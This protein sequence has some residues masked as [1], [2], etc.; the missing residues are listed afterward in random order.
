MARSEARDSRVQTGVGTNTSTHGMRHLSVSSDA[1]STK[2]RQP[3]NV[4]ATKRR[5]WDSAVRRTVR[6]PVTS[7]ARREPFRPLL[8]VLSVGVLAEVAVP[9][10]VI[11]LSDTL[12]FDTPAWMLWL[13]F[14][15]PAGLTLMA[16]LAYFAVETWRRNRPVTVEFARVGVRTGR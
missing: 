2:F 13:V 3:V 9:W 11:W 4:G 14:G 7:H 10:L 12:L 16:V 15:A 5:E 6:A 8:F 1:T